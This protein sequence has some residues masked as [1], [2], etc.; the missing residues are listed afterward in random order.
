LDEVLK[1]IEVTNLDENEHKEYIQMLK[2]FKQLH[3]GELMGIVVCKHRNGIFDVKL[4]KISHAFD[5]S[6]GR[7][8]MQN[9]GDAPGF[10]QKRMRDYSLPIFSEPY[11]RLSPHTAQAS[12]NPL[13]GQQLMVMVTV[14]GLQT[15]F[16]L[17]H[18]L[19]KV[20]FIKVWVHV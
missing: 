5:K 3:K 20:V 17:S 15:V 7:R 4:N 14:S 8:C 18:S 19:I 16:T 12:Y 1:T 6:L 10:Q 9:N 13:F 11:L 2:N